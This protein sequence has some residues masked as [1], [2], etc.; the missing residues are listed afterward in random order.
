MLKVAIVGC[1]KIADDHAQQIRRVRLGNLV[2]FCDAE[3]LMAQQ[4]RDRFGGDAYNSV[5]ELLARARPDVVHI[6][7]PPQSHFPLA[8]ECLEAN[9]HVFVEKPFTMNVGEA[10][11]LLGAA[12]SR[13]LKVSVDHNLQFTE[14][15][16]RLRALVADGFL[17]GPPV[18]LESYYCYDLSD[19]GYARSFLSDS[20]HWVRRLPGGLL[21][22]IISHGIA[23]IAEHVK[24]EDPGVTAL[25]RTSPML[26]SLGEQRLRDELRVLVHDD[27]TTAYF[28]F[29]SQ[30]RPQV[31]ELRIFGHR[32]A[33]L[34]DD[35]HH[36]LV[37]LHG[38]KY[39]SYLDMVVP[40]LNVSRGFFANAARNVRSLVTGRL[41]M[42]EGMK[43][44]IE[45]FYRSI[46]DD[47][48]V[49]IPYR[50]IVLTSRIMDS[51]FAQLGT[52]REVPQDRAATAAASAG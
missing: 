9:C 14:P 33:L 15:A 30:M 16:L 42:S 7:T 4:M 37:K 13:H 10:E 22:N 5:A 21:Q 23:R 19:P 38:D 3:P 40:P 41:H 49:P 17:G 31:S 20:A 50:E 44:L 18:H 39:K 8:M 28:T 48:P 1:G 36:L 46:V 29:S 11:R 27:T 47:G 26:R 43:E 45:R 24:S 51:V 12:A 34:L 6:T 25:G 32:N 2:A 35:N 52:V